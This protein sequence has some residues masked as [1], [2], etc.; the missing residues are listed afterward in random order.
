M[1]LTLPTCSFLLAVAALQAT[2]SAFAEVP[3]TIRNVYSEAEPIADMTKLNI[4]FERGSWVVSLGQREIIRDLAEKLADLDLIILVEAYTDSEGTPQANLILSEKRANAVAESLSTDNAV[5]S[6]RIITKG[7]G[8]EFASETARG[9]DRKVRVTLF[10]SRDNPQSREQII[11]SLKAKEIDVIERG[12]GAP[13]LQAANLAGDEAFPRIGAGIHR[14]FLLYGIEGIDPAS[15]SGFWLKANLWRLTDNFSLGAGVSQ[16]LYSAHTATH[17]FNIVAMTYNGY[18]DWRLP[19]GR[20]YALHLSAHIGFDSYAIEQVGE[21]AT[22][23]SSNNTGTA[24]RVDGPEVD[25]GL[26]SPA[27]GYGIHPA[28]VWRVPKY[29]IFPTIAADLSKNEFGTRF[30]A[31]LGIWFGW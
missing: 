12:P 25:L 1:R 15:G 14:T 3:I 31:L 2:C 4:Y 24:P 17:S 19:R 22:A 18:L 11:A 21:S 5:R 16:A 6:S 10:R 26:R 28:I 9:D 20:Y 27:L 7:Y 13:A 23:S 29:S 8:A 30:G